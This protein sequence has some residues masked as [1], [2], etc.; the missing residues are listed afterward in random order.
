MNLNNIIVARATAQNLEGIVEVV[1]NTFPQDFNFGKGFN[2]EACNSMFARAI[3]DPN[4]L[5]CVALKDGEVI[6]FTYYINKPPTNG[7]IILEM[8]GV[9]KDFQGKGIGIK[10]ITGADEE[11]VHYFRDECGVPNLATIHLTTSADNPVGQKLYLEAG[12]E[13]VGDIPGMV[14]TGNVEF[15]MLK[16]I[17]YVNYRKGLWPEKKS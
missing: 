16:K 10:L 2:P 1:Y 3:K 14:G 4:E 17:G 15:V 7:T 5:V 6:G 8:I 13:H 11:A 9:Q 12:Y